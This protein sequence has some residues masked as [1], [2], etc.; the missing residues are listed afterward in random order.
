MIHIG[1]QSSYDS[2]SQLFPIHPIHKFR[3][4]DRA[5]PFRIAIDSLRNV[6]TKRLHICFDGGGL[7]IEAGIGAE[8]F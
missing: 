4:L 3:A 1:R 2:S 5:L 8:G 6:L 7:V